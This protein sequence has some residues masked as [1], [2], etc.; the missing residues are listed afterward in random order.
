MTKCPPD[1]QETI[2]APSGDDCKSQGK[3]QP[4]KSVV[5]K[6]VQKSLPDD[7]CQALDWEDQPETHTKAY[8]AMESD[9]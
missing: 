8:H 4:Q 3:L 5:E 6:L 7:S 2:W 9:Q 1:L